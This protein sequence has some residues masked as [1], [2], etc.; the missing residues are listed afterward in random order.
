MKHVFTAEDHNV[1]G[2]LGSAVA[3]D[4]AEHAIAK[5]LTRLGV[6]DT[7][8]ESGSPEA[9]YE[10]HGLNAHGLARSIKGTL[11]APRS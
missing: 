4:L 11:N 3:E 8:G 7:Y 1:I 2:G 9:L 5:P 6:H 10:K